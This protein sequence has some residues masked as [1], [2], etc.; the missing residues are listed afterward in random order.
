MR[1]RIALF[2]LGFLLCALFLIGCSRKETSQS[3]SSAPQQIT[4]VDPATA[5]LISGTI[6]FSGTAPQPQKID[7]SL[8][9]ACKG[10]NETENVVVSDGKLAN[11]FVYVK[12]GLEGKAFALP[13]QPAKLDQSGCRYRPHV[14]GLMTGQQLEI[15]NSDPTTHNVH[16]MPNVNRAFN[17]AQSPY[18][19]PVTHTFPQPEIMVPVKCNVHPWM[20]AYLNIVPHPF[21]AVTG[22]DGRFEIQGLPPGTYTIAAVQEDLG[23]RDQTVTVAP[24][25]SKAVDFSFSRSR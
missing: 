6:S 24:K 7:M 13:S 11:V 14:L 8:D 21:F 5:A 12:T 16:P 23:E 2:L 20:R 18:A 15:T 3:Q 10:T 25:E 1:P 19:A 22:S 17:A 9:S 4:H